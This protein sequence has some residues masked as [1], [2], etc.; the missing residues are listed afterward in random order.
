[1][2]GIHTALITPFDADDRVDLDAFE[3]L[4]ARQL[5][6]GVH[7]LVPCGT[8]GETPTLDDD[9]IDALVRAA[10]RVAGGQAPVTAGIGSNSTRHAIRNAE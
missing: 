5:D 4:C 3:R 2:H 1:M 7:G 9:E 8:T 6:A 10:A